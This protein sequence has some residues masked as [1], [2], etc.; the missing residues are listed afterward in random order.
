MV[1]TPIE[2]L[3]D[4]PIF[5]EHNHS[6]IGTNGKMKDK[7]YTSCTTKIHKF[8]VKK[9]WEAIALGYSRKYG[10]TAEYWLEQ[11]KIKNKTSCEFGSGLHLARELH[12]K[13]LEDQGLDV[14]T[15]MINAEGWKQAKPLSDLKVGTHSELMIWS[16]V[17][18]I[19]GQS[20]Q[21]N[22]YPGRRVK[23]SDYKSNE[24]I[25]FEGF[26]G[27]TLTGP[28][29]HIPNA[30]YHIYC[31]QLSTYAYLLEMQGYEVVELE[32][33]HLTDNNKVYK[34]PYLREDVINMLNYAA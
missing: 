32:L 25:K 6:Y 1:L 12:W 31:I 21:V 29:S 17:F 13:Y 15:N 28:L 11:W 24:K 33:I 8:E 34:L 5:W 18:E 9:D 30:N 20:D 19:C 14:F 27:E 26:K 16:E 2:V 4:L 23:V 3:E 7:K 22:V 10:Y